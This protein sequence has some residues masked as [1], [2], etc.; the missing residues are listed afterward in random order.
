MSQTVNFRRLQLVFS[1][2]F[3]YL[4]ESSY[5]FS[6]FAGLDSFGGGSGGALL[7]N[8]TSIN[9][10]LLPGG[11]I[12]TGASRRISNALVGEAKYSRSRRTT[13]TLTGNYGLL[14]FLESGYTNIHYFTFI[15]GDNYR[16]TTRDQFA[17]D[18]IDTLYLFSGGSR[19]LLTRAV[20]LSYS[21]LLTTRLTLT[22]TLGPS[23]NTVSSGTGQSLSRFLLTTNDRL[24]YRSKKLD[25][26]ARFMRY[27]NPGA[28]VLR[29]AES[30]MAN[31]TASRHVFGK[32]Y[33]GVDLGHVYNQSLAQRSS[34]AQRTRFETWETGVHLSHEL[35]HRASL[36]A[37]YQFQH[38]ISNRQMCF[39]DACGTVYTRHIIGVGVNWHGRPRRIH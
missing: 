17:A 2:Q 6:G 13:F 27:T 26:D 3:S 28:G 31:L 37:H 19:A 36:Y 30:E 12:L 24:Q 18:Y 38:Q 23:I 1:D 25:L 14:Q 11:S 4:P 7:G 15:A 20:E 39:G 22:L 10:G 29:G 33:G 16:L 34:K 9:P 35:S 8:T 21:R 32:F 5:G